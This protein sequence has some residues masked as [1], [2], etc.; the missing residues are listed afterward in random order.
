MVGRQLS[1]RL[2]AGPRELFAKPVGQ[3]R[4]EHGHA[5]LA[6]HVDGARGHDRVLD[7]HV[8]GALARG[9]KPECARVL[10]PVTCGGGAV[11]AR[12]RR[13][14]LLEGA[15]VG[16]ARAGGARR[17][18]RCLPARRARRDDPLLCCPWPTAAGAAAAH[19][20]AER[21]HV[22]VARG[23]AQARDFGLPH[24]FQLRL[25]RAVPCTTVAGSHSGLCFHVHAAIKLPVLLL[26]GQAPGVE[27]AQVVL[28]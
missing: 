11:R 9:A 5:I 18:A 3:G 22:H 23:A 1:T 27:Q 6:R 12:A 26:G 25:A 8:R 24:G 14:Q 19:G 28:C 21:L 7:A 10:R 2:E 17:H 15:G 13:V 4:G 16:A 20:G